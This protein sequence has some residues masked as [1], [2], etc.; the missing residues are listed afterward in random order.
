MYVL[1]DGEAFKIG[2]TDGYVAA[3]VADL[4]TGNQRLIRTVAEVDS[5]SPAVEKHL[6]EFDQG[7]GGASGSSGPHSRSWQPTPAAGRSC[8]AGG[9]HRHRQA[10]GTSSRTP[11]DAGLLSVRLVLDGCLPAQRVDWPVRYSQLRCA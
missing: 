9:C 3:R 10:T 8:C 2:Y 11:R 1:S 6:A 5:A 7:P 4:Q